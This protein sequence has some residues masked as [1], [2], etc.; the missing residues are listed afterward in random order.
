MK[1]LWLICVGILLVGC[2]TTHYS[3]ELPISPKCMDNPEFYAR[4]RND[5]EHIIIPEVNFKNVRMPDAVT[6]WVDLTRTHDPKKQGVGVIYLDSSR[7]KPQPEPG[8]TEELEALYAKVCRLAFFEAYEQTFERKMTDADYKVFNKLHKE[9]KEKFAETEGLK[10]W[11]AKYAEEE[12]EATAEEDVSEPS[13]C[14]GAEC[15]DPFCDCESE[16]DGFSFSDD[17]DGFDD[18]DS[19]SDE[20]G[21]FD[22]SEQNRVQGANLGN[23]RETRITIQAKNI[24]ALD[25]MNRMVEAADLYWVIYPRLYIGPKWQLDK[26]AE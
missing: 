4:I 24:S 21:D 14:V 26:M 5:L 11:L 16:N 23:S 10:E 12:K 13:G 8:S 7:E 15:E 17:A 20:I 19:F 18:S 22:D 6:R 25:L 3:R 9:A 1:S 2:S